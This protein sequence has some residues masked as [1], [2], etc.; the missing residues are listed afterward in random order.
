[1]NCYMCLVK[2]KDAMRS[3]HAVCQRCGVGVCHQHLVEMTDKPIVGPGACM[4]AFHPR[5]L[6]CRSCYEA[7]YTTDV[8]PRP[9][10][11][12][13]SPTRRWWQYLWFWHIPSSLPSPEEAVASVEGFLKQQRHL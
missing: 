5:T 9:Q 10:K 7:M 4:S 1:M 2:H 12:L 8:E 6:L 13:S 11:M 3:A